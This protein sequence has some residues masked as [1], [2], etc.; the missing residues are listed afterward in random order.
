M[1]SLLL[2]LWLRFAIV[3]VSERSPD[4]EA[5]PRGVAYNRG[6]LYRKS[7]EFNCLDGSKSILYNQVNDDYCDC[8]DGSDEPGT[9][10]CPNGKFHCA[11]KGHTG[12][13]IP[14]SRVN[15]KICDCC[16]GSDEYSGAVECP[17]ICE[18]LGRSAREEMR[19]Q[20]EIA[21]K[22]F[23]IRKTL[24]AEGQKLRT[25]K[26]NALAPL[27]EEREKLIPA[28]E[29]LEKKKTEAADRERALKD[30]HRDAW[31]AVKEEKKKEKSNLMFKEI[32]ANGD[33]KITL[34]EMKK[35]EYLD[36]DHDGTVS[37]DEAKVYLTVDEADSE[38]FLKN[39][40][41]NL[42]SE[43]LS[44]EDFKKHENETEE[45]HDSEGGDKLESTTLEPETTTEDDDYNTMPPY[46]DE[47]LKASDEA[48]AARKEYDEVDD[49]VRTL[50]S[51]ISEAESFVQQD[52]DADFAWVA[53]KGKCFELNEQ[54]YTYKL[55][56]FDRT[57]QKDR[58]GHETSLGNWKEW[59]GAPPAKYAKQSYKNGVQCWNG[60]ERSTEVEIQCGETSELVSA[61]EPAKCEYY[62]V[63][64]TPAAC[65]DPDHE[66]PEHLEL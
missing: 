44:A 40:Y 61:T 55:C 25:E 1:R 9:S 36:T 8:P 16:D 2:C 41:D 64:R 13:D 52:F 49:K 19:R 10:A 58:N 50:D 22:G 48:D 39:M 28:K 42:K 4:I 21:R 57:V 32:D 60:P 12:A 20:S 66:Q 24:A 54:Q 18:E 47:T 31:M 27:K 56:V 7:F 35:L 38:H 15:D 37:D 14:S 45:E 17:N 34:D 53:L 51:Q 11:N 65:K 6:S 29:A 3:V 43:K 59:S 30:K 26:L 5:L 63:F 23:A 62:F 46:D 33:Q